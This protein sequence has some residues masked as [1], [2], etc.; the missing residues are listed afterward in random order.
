MQKWIDAGPQSDLEN[1]DRKSLDTAV[2][3]LLLVKD[4]GKLF[5]VSAIC[6]HARARMD[7]GDIEGR[8]LECPLHGARFDLQTGRALCL[9]AVE[10][11]R[12]FPVRQEAG[13]IWICLSNP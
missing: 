8:A 2:G 3:P 5:A 11:I 13:R 4:G 6:P 10:P 12:V 9:P 7:D 1:T